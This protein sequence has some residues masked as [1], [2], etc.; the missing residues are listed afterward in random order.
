MRLFLAVLV[1]LAGTHVHAQVRSNCAEIADSLQRLTCYDSENSGIADDDVVFTEQ[2]VSNL[3]L[4]TRFWWED[5]NYGTSQSRETIVDACNLYHSYVI[6]NGN[7]RYSNDI[8]WRVHVVNLAHVQSATFGF[9]VVSFKMKPDHL[10]YK[11]TFATDDAGV[12]TL[13]VG[14]KFSEFSGYA[15]YRVEPARIVD[16]QNFLVSTVDKPETEEILN[17]MIRY[18]SKG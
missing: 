11:I 10:G 4:F 12:E 5:R 6:N 7:P 18:C 17:R 2:D 9:A 16:I 1:V 14:R 3:A 13:S 8:S 15:G